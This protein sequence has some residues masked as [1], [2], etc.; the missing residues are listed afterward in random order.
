VGVTKTEA[1]REE[2]YAES[3]RQHNAEQ[4][5]AMLWR[6]CAYHQG[7]IRTQQH[8]SATIIS[9]H[10][11]ALARIEHKLGINGN[12]KERGSE[13]DLRTASR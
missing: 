3:C 6:W 2:L 8:I 11:R 4:Q 5:E 12:G 7:R 10:E 9:Q 13:R 1:E